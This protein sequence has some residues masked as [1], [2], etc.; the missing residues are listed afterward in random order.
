MCNGFEN[1]S[2]QFRKNCSGFA[3]RHIYSDYSFS[4][5]QKVIYAVLCAQLANS[6]RCNFEKEARVRILL[7]H[8]YAF[9]VRLG[10]PDMSGMHAAVLAGNGEP[11]RQN[12]SLRDLDY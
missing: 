3:E 10:I 9:R 7:I 2:L 6:S 11:L 4:C 1:D 12:Y 8:E 5:V